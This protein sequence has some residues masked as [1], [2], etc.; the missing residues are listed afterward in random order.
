MPTEFT[1]IES[2]MGGVLIGLSAVLLMALHGRVAG[3]T[4]ILA[5]AIFDKDR[6]WRLTFIAGLILAPILFIALGNPPQI[7][8]PVSRTAIILGGLLVGVGVTLGSGCT[9]GHGVCGLARMSRRSLLA[10]VTF[11][12]TALL[13]VFLARHVLEF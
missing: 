12:A 1:P 4:G 13:T 9:S 10:T 11:M 3:I 2:T 6:L 5:G 7:E 8:I